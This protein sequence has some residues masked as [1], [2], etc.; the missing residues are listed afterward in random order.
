MDNSTLEREFL[1]W[2]LRQASVAARDFEMHRPDFL[3]ISPPKTASTWLADNL[4]C[5]PEVFVP[6]GKELKYFSYYS[7]WLDLNWY[8]NQFRAA[9]DRVKGEASPSYAILPVETM[10]RIHCLMPDLKLIFLMREPIARSWSH[11][12][13]NFR[14]HE[15][16]F[17]ADASDFEAVSE[18]QWR[19]NFVHEWPLSNGDYLEQL[20]RWMSVFP[21]EH[22]YVD[23]YE[24]VAHDPHKLLRN[25]FAFLGVTPDVDLSSFPLAEKIFS[26]LPGELSPSLR[27][28]LQQLHG[29]RTRELAA[30]L[31]KQ[32]GLSLPSEWEANLAPAVNAPKKLFQN[33]T[34]DGLQPVS[35]GLESNLQ[36]GFENAPKEEGQATSVETPAMAFPRDFEEQDLAAV[37]AR[38]ESYAPMPISI[39]DAY[40]GYKIV[41]HRGQFLVLGPEFNLSR[42]QAMGPAELAQFG[43]RGI[44]FVASSLVEAKEHADQL[45]WTEI[46]AQLQTL[47]AKAKTVE[48]LQT[49]VDAILFHEELLYRFFTKPFRFIVST[50]VRQS[51]RQLQT[52]LSSMF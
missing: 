42:L 51:F 4:R 37:L 12:K 5:H 49:S 9:G 18:S 13:H 14:F 1:A 46:H 15:A 32:F 8:L 20:R 43:D 44:A 40:R 36:P 30:F 38:G 50:Q 33:L 26:G 22:F 2:C 47:Q 19:E 48:P 25:V 29:E 34:W 27:S 39:V 41:L 52:F 16:N 6:A 45:A 11:A 23:F 3:I 21:R 10:R 7:Q 35:V 17:V 24:S 28:C 31:G